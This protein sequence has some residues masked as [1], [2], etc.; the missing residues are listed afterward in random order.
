[1]RRCTDQQIS[2]Q[3][4]LKESTTLCSWFFNSKGHLARVWPF[5]LRLEVAPLSEYFYSLV[6]NRTVQ[7]RTITSTTVTTYTYDDANRLDYFYEDGDQTDLAWDNNGNLLTQGTSVYTWDAANRLV[8]ADVGGV[9]STFVYNGLGQRTSQTVDGV[10]TEYVLDVATGLP[11]VIVATTGGA[12]TYYVQVSG[13]ILAQYGSSAWAYALPDHLGSVRQLVGSDSQTDLAQSFDPFGVPFEASGSGQ[14]PFG[15]TGEWWESYSQLVFLRTRHYDPAVGRFLSKDSFP[16]FSQRPRTLHPYVYVTN[17]PANGTDPSGYQEGVQV[18][19]CLLSNPA[20]QAAVAE[21]M[22]IVALTIEFA[23]PFAVIVGPP[24]ILM[25]LS[26]KYGVWIEPAIQPE[27]VPEAKDYYQPYP[28]SPAPPKDR[29]LDPPIPQVPPT[30]CYW[31]ADGCKPVSAIPGREPNPQ[32]ESTPIEVPYDPRWKLPTPPPTCTET[33]E[34]KQKHISLG[35]NFDERNGNRPILW[36]FTFN[37]NEK[38]NSQNI[39]VYA[40]GDWFK[41]GLSS[42]PPLYDFSRA[43][44]DATERAEG[45]HFNLETVGD[46]NEYVERYGSSGEFAGNNQWT[47]V[48]LYRIKTRPQLC[49]KTKFYETGSFNT[50]ESMAAWQQICGQ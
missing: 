3:I 18:L 21:A 11:E 16:G 33:P 6:G 7:T 45:I 44:D 15:Y 28:P 10:T 32:P 40:Y 20:C 24:V 14:S 1:L 5:P 26:A 29:P 31:S 23:G 22:A 2:R 48:E 46:P 34:P 13:Q 36:H 8:S 43:F 49:N 12:S 35:R 42:V 37:L 47:A 25:A 50:V 38:L 41:E 39:Y 4:V 19:Q 9:V 17:N 27:P 30:P